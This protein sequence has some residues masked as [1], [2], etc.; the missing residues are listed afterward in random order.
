MDRRKETWAKAIGTRGFVD[1]PFH[2]EQML[3]VFE[4]ALS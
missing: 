1:K 2:Q 3:K 4:E